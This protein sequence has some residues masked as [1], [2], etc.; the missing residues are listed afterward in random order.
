MRPFYSTIPPSELTAILRANHVTPTDIDN[1]RDPREP[2][3]FFGVYEKRRQNTHSIYRARVLKFIELGRRFNTKQEAATAIVAWY[4][5]KYTS[6]KWLKV[7]R[8]R[9]VNPWRVCEVKRELVWSLRS[10]KI[11]TIGYKA[12]IYVNG[13]PRIVTRA[14]LGST[15]LGARERYL[16]AER[17]DAKTAAKRAA[18]IYMQQKKLVSMGLGM[19]RT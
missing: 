10:D 4:K 8:N 11:E 3:R 16:W 19:W 18:T 17:E 5:H 14:M 12:E 9:R 7:Y 13:I 15:E 2:S 6:D 1:L